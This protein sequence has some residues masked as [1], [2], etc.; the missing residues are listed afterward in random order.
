MVLNTQKSQRLFRAFITITSPDQMLRGPGSVATS[1]KL[2]WR[3]RGSCRRIRGTGA[4]VCGR[5]RAIGGQQRRQSG[6]WV[7]F[8]GSRGTAVAPAQGENASAA[9]VARQYPLR[10]EG[11]RP[12]GATG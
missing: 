2:A 6:P 8:S 3:H 5:W 7:R 12:R 10:I 11:A 1:G 4:P 9:T